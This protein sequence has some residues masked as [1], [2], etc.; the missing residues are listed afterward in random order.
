MLPEGEQL[1]RA[2][3]WISDMRLED[4]EV[5]QAKL[6]A[7]ACLKFDLPPKYAEFIMMHF[8]KR[9]STNQNYW[10]KA[11]I[12]S[13]ASAVMIISSYLVAPSKRAGD[14]L[15]SIDSQDKERVIGNSQINRTAFVAL[16]N[17][18]AIDVVLTTFK[19]T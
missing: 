12:M 18:C 9:I 11:R 7:E 2:V 6:I 16:A 1:R 13:G 4:S 15:W 19:A 5:S 3:K 17:V 8:A 10:P 14:S